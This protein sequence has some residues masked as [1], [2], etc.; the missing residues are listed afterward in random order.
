MAG[1]LPR[2]PPVASPPGSV[3]TQR[4]R[5]DGV[6][7]I[8]ISSARAVPGRPNAPPA[9]FVRTK[10]GVFEKRTR[11]AARGLNPKW[12]EPLEMRGKLGDFLKPLSVSICMDPA[13]A[14]ASAAA[15]QRLKPEV[16]CAFR[17][18]GFEA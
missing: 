4:E 9:P 7:T 16:L 17:V 8:L 15:R 2:S 10:L 1:R 11:N 3:S 14:G 5:Q 18:G 13:A 6:L 12:D